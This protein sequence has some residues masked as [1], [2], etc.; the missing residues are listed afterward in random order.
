MSKIRRELDL[1]TSLSTG[2]GLVRVE[3]VGS[4]YHYDGS[5]MNDL[6]GL[7]SY[8]QSVGYVYYDTKIIEGRAHRRLFKHTTNSNTLEVPNNSYLVLVG[9]N[10]YILNEAEFQVKCRCYK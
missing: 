9:T 2:H 8:L 1:P 10:V 6:G 3:V 7:V 5:S 4:Y